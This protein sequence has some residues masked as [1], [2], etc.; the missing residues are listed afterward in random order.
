MRTKPS[1]MLPISACLVAS[2]IGPTPPSLAAL[3]PMR[4]GSQPSLSN[5]A[6]VMAFEWAGDIWVGSPH[7]GEARRLTASPAYDSHPV[8]SPDGARIAFRSDRGG[9]S[10]VYLVP[11]EGGAPRCLTSHSEGSRPLDWTPDGASV[12][13]I[14]RR[15]HNW[16]RADRLFVVDVQGKGPERLVLNAYANKGRFQGPDTLLVTRLGAPWWRQGYQGSRASQAWRVDRK[17]GEFTRLFPEKAAVRDPLWHAPS[18]S[19]L[20]LSNE[21]GVFNL[22]RLDRDGNEQRLTSFEE[23]ALVT[24]TLASEAGVVVFRH[25]FDFY[26]LNLDS[27]GGPEKISLVGRTDTSPS[28]I[29]RRLL[30]EATEVAFSN[31]G[32]EI[33]FVAGHDLW[34]MDTVLRRP[35][36]VTS[37]PSPESSP[38]FSPD[39]TLLAFVSEVEGQPDAWIA[40]RAD[41]DAYWWQND[42]FNSRRLTND[43]GEESNLRF[44]PSGERLAFA[45]GLGELRVVD[46]GGTRLATIDTGWDP[47]SFEWSPQGNH[48]GYAVRDDNY[49]RDV[50]VVPADGSS[51]PVNIS[52]HP[53]DDRSPCWSPDGSR[54][55]YTGVR[56]DDETD[57]FIAHLGESPPST[58]YDRL[59][60][61]VERMRSTRSASSDLVDPAPEPTELS[62][63]RLSDRVIRLKNPGVCESRLLWSPDSDRIAFTGYNG[64]VSDTYTLDVDGEGRPKRLSD[65][66]GSGGRWLPDDQIVW[67][68]GDTPGQLDTNSKNYTKLSFKAYQIGNRGER[69]RAVLLQCWRVVRDRFYDESFHGTDWESVLARY[70]PMAEQCVDERMLGNVIRMMLGELNASHQG[71]T[72]YTF[73]ETESEWAERTSHLGLWFKP[74]AEAGLEIIR[75]AAN[76]DQAGLRVGQHLTHLNGEPI[77]SADQVPG[78]LTGE[79]ET[80]VT[81]RVAEGGDSE[82]TVLPITYSQARD[83]AYHDWV[84]RTTKQVAELS[85]GRLGYLH[86]RGMG[87]SNFRRAEEDLFS[88]TNGREGLIVDVRFN[89]GGWIADRLLAMFAHPHHAVAFPRGGGPGYPQDRRVYAT[90]NGPLIALCNESSISNAEIFS[91]AIQSTGRGSLVGQTTAGDVISTGSRSIMG[92]G[93]MRVTHRGWRVQSTGANM[94]GTGAVPDTLVA[95]APGDVAASNDKQLEAAVEA[96]LDQ[97]SDPENSAVSE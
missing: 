43:P 69:L 40:E 97:L 1:G 5:D 29:E 81:V 17:S 13:T 16:T 55:A 82:L 65:W 87:T 33:A 50:Y 45:H 52:R 86:I 96:L 66:T 30:N 15:D 48:F 64:R 92:V 38:V 71:F 77:T 75:T 70:A 85:D 53:D 95:N 41:A 24:P 84:N 61:A 28:E 8:V 57:I 19:L 44:D 34:V 42:Q 72:R 67:L 27:A 90:W 78:R 4:M 93:R 46:L 20:Y 36:R 7:G 25:L 68:S 58:R 79:P 62:V 88:A 60:T 47:P 18:E 9:T 12:L 14:G 3:T 23:G 89:G 76:A 10:Q 26:R 73:K 49:N 37:T 31:D 32:L 6:S 74:S 80:P 21:T 2:L 91:H 22:Y 35:R 11:T 39:G 94:E 51:S 83:E 54:I 63:D 56:E 59:A